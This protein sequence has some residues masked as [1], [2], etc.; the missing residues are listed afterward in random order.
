MIQYRLKKA[1][2]TAYFAFKKAVLGLRIWV[3]NCI[4]LSS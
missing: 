2:L 3:R 4:I 1:V